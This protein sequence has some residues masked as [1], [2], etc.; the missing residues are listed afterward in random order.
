MRQDLYDAPNPNFTGEFDLMRN[1]ADSSYN[2]LQVQFRH[3]LSHGL[4]TLLSY[5][6]AHAIDDDSSDAFPANLSPNDAPLSQERGSSDYHIRHTFSGA[7][8]YNIPTPSGGIGKAILG[9]WSTDSIVYARSAPPVNV[10][11]GLD[12]FPFGE[13]ETGS[14]GAVRPNLVPGVPLWIEDPNVAGGREIN[15]AAFT[16][17]GTASGSA[18]Q[19]DLGRNALRGFDATEVDLTLRRQFHL[20]ERLAPQARADLFNIFNHPNFGSPINYLSSPQFGQSTQMLGA[21][22]G[23]GGQNGGLNPLYQ[24]GGPRSAQLALKLLF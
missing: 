22:L 7:V 2:A 4:Q 11:T 8:S 9:N 6:W 24:I 1:D 23:T 18:V 12:P 16:I 20:W 21:S 19:G 14:L 13:I 15:P 17:P 3:R 10:V 5:T